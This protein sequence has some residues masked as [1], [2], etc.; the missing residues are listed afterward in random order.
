M[1]VKNRKELP[2][3]PRCPGELIAFFYLL[4]SQRHAHT[5][6]RVALLSDGGKGRRGKPFFPPLILHCDS[7]VHGSHERAK[8]AEL[9]NEIWF[10]PQRLPLSYGCMCLDRRNEWMIEQ[11]GNKWHRNSPRC[12]FRPPP[13]LQPRLLSR[14]ASHW[15]SLWW[16]R[17]DLLATLRQ[18]RMQHL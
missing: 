17:C 9:V 8:Q 5:R 1:L 7:W 12:L 14:W 3:L 4:P 13:S 16:L 6:R 18:Q 11:W 15:C 10:L 2:S